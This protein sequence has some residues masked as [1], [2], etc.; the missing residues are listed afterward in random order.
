MSIVKTLFPAALFFLLCFGL[1]SCGPRRVGDKIAVSCPDRTVLIP[2][3]CNRAFEVFARDYVEQTRV[4][5]GD[6][7]QLAIEVDHKVWEEVKNTRQTLDQSAV[8]Y[9]TSLT[10][11]CHQ[12]SYDPCNRRLYA[13]LSGMMNRV[14]QSHEKM[15]RSLDQAIG[16]VKAAMAEAKPEKHALK[17]V[18]IKKA[19]RRKSIQSIRE[20]RENFRET[21]RIP[22]K[23]PEQL[24]N[25]KKNTQSAKKTL[26]RTSS[27]Y[28]PSY[29]S[30]S[31]DKG[32]R[33]TNLAGAQKKAAEAVKNA[34]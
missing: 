2:A 26:D 33:G 10:A 5:I 15:E 34:K 6:L 24:S 23:K 32:N 19:A 14:V 7:E 17:P 25:K 13:E 11:F 20:V 22:D 16:N 1:F 4:R 31:V 18:A 29:R 28:K 21:F 8:R 12:L 30:P 27:G 3:D 9:R